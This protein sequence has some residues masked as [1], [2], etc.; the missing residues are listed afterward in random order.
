MQGSVATS[1]DL[2]PSGNTQGD[3]Y[4]VQEDDSLWIWDGA[5]WVSGG[6]IQ[7]P[8]GATGP[9]GAQGPTG[10]QGLKGDTGATGPEGP[11]GDP[12]PQGIQGVPGTPG[13]GVPTGG[14]ATHVLTK[15]SAT[16]YDTAWQAPSGGITLPLTQHLTFSPD[17]TYDIGASAASRPRDL[18]VGRHIESG[19]NLS[20]NGTANVAIV[21]AG[22]VNSTGNL[23]VGGTLSVGTAMPAGLMTTVKA[24]A[25]GNSSGDTVGY[26]MYSKAGTLLA[27]LWTDAVAGTT[28]LKANG[29]LA[30]HTGAGS[31]GFTA[32]NQ[33]M[34]I[35][36]DG[37][38]S[39]AGVL[40]VSGGAINVDHVRTAGAQNMMGLTGN[41]GGET[42]FY[43][44]GPGG[45]RWVNSA[46]SVQ[47]MSLNTSAAL[48]VQGSITAVGRVQCA[49]VYLNSN[50][51]YFASGS[52]IFDS[53]GTHYYR[54]NGVHYFQNHGGA[55][56]IINAGRVDTPQV[57][58]PNGYY[59][60]YVSG[61]PM[62]QTNGH[63][64]AVSYTVSNT[65]ITGWAIWLPNN[66]D[67]MSRGVANAWSVHSAARYKTNV[68]PIDDPLAIVKNPKLHGHRYDN[69]NDTHGRKPSTPSTSPSIGF[70][71]DDWLSVLPEVVTLDPLTGQPAA[72]DY[73]RI[74]AVTFEAVKQLTQQVQELQD[75]VAQLEA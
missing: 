17:T 61:N 34:L 47:W 62:L 1:G 45:F 33:R 49:D 24:Y 73:D 4:I 66:A 58:F 41:G 25:G 38:V 54:S 70:I 2:P 65:S 29:Q 53:G 7:G 50:A 39:M 35:A 60:T 69:L 72:I 16:N 74:G 10:A 8:P 59:F 9:A 19:G 75:R 5:A 63:F 32:T 56:Q 68:R 20:V 48:A 55:A 14:A 67:S 44:A 18:F 64:T 26:H 40:T 21:Q 11:E 37:A 28:R 71:A 30:F 23:T 57:Y 22:S 6:S 15:V 12:G 51:L 42:L 3:A 13:Q 43:A 31:T 36:A 27:E 46:N 52:A